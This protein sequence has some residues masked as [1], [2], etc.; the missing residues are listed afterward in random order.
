MRAPPIRIDRLLKGNIGRIV[1]ADDRARTLGLERRGDAVGC[2]LEVPAIV[3]CL[4]L[5][6]IEAAGRIG[7]GAPARE[8]LAAGD[9]A[10][11][12]GTV[13]I[14]ISHVKSPAAA[15]KPAAATGT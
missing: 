12:G 11:H 15:E 1:G 13:Y 5:L 9:R 4:E 3:H 2:V 14:Y 6:K 8:R 7:Q 10:A